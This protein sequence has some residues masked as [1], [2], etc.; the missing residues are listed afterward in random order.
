MYE[1]IATAAAGIQAGVGLHA[2]VAGTPLNGGSSAQY[3]HHRTRFLSL[4]LSATS[5]GCAAAAYYEEGRGDLWLV[6]ATGAAL[7][8]PYHP[9]INVPHQPISPWK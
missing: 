4:V 1:L 7:S 6:A 8:V 9:L 5:C 3:Y 2:A